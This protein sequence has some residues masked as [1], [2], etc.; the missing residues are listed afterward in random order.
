MGLE[1]Y[2]AY[3]IT[4]YAVFYTF[5]PDWLITLSSTSSVFGDQNS[6]KG[7]PEPSL[8]MTSSIKKISPPRRRQGFTLILTNPMLISKTKTTFF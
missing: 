7:W 3:R 5:N 8:N 4:V 1:G 2:E 6:F